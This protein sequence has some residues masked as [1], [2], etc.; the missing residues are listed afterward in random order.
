MT[1]INA[2]AMPTNAYQNFCQIDHTLQKATMHK[3]HF[4]KCTATYG[5]VTFIKHT[6]THKH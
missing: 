3:I 4:Y 6:F 5:N 2:K 1:Y